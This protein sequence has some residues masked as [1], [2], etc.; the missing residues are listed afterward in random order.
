[1]RAAISGGS[2]GSA[3]LPLTNTQT[4]ALASSVGRTVRVTDVP[5]DGAT[6]QSTGVFT[7]SA[8]P[9]GSP[10]AY[11][12]PVTEAVTADASAAT[13]CLLSADG[14]ACELVISDLTGSSHGCELT[15]T[16]Q[17]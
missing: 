12:L 7:V 14:G 15:S 1:M 11:S 4:I 16:T 17:G 2:A 13:R 5:N 6:C 3:S 9:T 8:A 10:D